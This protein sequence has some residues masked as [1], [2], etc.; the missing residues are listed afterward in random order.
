MLAPLKKSYD[1]PRQHM[2]EQRHYFASKS[3]CSQSYGFSSSHVQMWELNH[4]VG[5]AL[6]NWCFW[7][8]VLEKTLE[9]PLDS[10]EIK[11]VNT[12]GNQPWIF[13]GMT[14]TEAPILW[15]PDVKT[16]LIGKNPDAGK[17]WGEGRSRRGRQ[18]IRWSGGVT[19][20]MDR[21]LSKLWEIV[22]DKEAWCAAVHGVPKS[23]T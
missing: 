20:L 16:C 22:K 12:K 21:S 23:Q 2:K 9:S 5:W 17:D 4:K 7:M 19:D 14:D 6:K 1:Q 18:N 10:K 11:S 3:P 13:T 8:V 15:L